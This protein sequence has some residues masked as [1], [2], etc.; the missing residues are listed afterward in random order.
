M[1]DVVA[2]AALRELSHHG[3]RVT[4]AVTILALRYHLVLGLMAG[5][6]CQFAMF[7]LTCGKKIK[8]FL[9]AGGAIFG[10]RLV[11]IGYVFRRMRLVAFFAVGNRLVGG[12]GFVALGAERNFAVAVMAEAAGQGGMLTLVVAQFDD[13][14]GVTGYAG[15]SH[16]IAIGNIKRCVRVFMTAYTC[17][18][19]VM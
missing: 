2:H 19:F 4:V 8:R 16:V 7:K 18:Q 10:R 14:S 17:R 9:M 6:T 15:I 1:G 3:R 5:C 12:M 11:V 13:L